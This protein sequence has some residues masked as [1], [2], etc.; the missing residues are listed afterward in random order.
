MKQNHVFFFFALVLLTGFFAACATS[1]TQYNT[2]YAQYIRHD[3]DAALEILAKITKKDP[4]F[5]PSHLLQAEIFLGRGE[6]DRAEK[7]LLAAEEILPGDHM[8]PFNL[9]N[10]Y[11]QKNEYQKAIEF[12]S[13]SIT[14]NPNFNKAYLNRANLYLTI[15]SYKNALADYDSFLSL[16]PEGY[17]NVKRLA[18][19]LRH[20]LEAISR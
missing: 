7:A 14:L 20:D 3:N 19:L 5:L 4:S 8:I 6:T 17:E 11:Y 1:Q 13:K 9:G 18:A 2:A 12:Y 16:T 10:L 15:K